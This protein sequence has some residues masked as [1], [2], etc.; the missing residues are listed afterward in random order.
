MIYFSI[1]LFQ[2][3]EKDR[4][5]NIYIMSFL[6]PPFPKAES[7]NAA[8]EEVAL[9]T[10]VFLWSTTFFSLLSVWLTNS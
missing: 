7:L 4:V 10:N 9:Q 8:E 6:N 2:E 1:S 3:S 5:L